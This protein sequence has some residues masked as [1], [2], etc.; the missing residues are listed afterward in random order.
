MGGRERYR[1]DR[2]ESGQFG[3]AE[4]AGL[5]FV[6]QELDKSTIKGGNCRTGIQ[7]SI[8]QNKPTL[9]ET[10]RVHHIKCNDIRDTPT[11]TPRIQDGNNLATWS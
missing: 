5:D 6:G 1:R 9:F 7:S 4:F 2:L 8:I 3:G 10:Q 11:I